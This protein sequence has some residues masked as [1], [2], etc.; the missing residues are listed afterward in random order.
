MPDRRAVLRGPARGLA[1]LRRPARPDRPGAAAPRGHRD[2]DAVGRAERPWLGGRRRHRVSHRARRAPARPDPRGDQGRRLRCGAVHLVVDGA[3][4]RRHRGQA[5]R[6]H[7]RRLHRP[8]DRRDRGRVRAARGRD[9]A[10]AVDGGAGGRAGRVRGRARGTRPLP[11]G[12]KLR[13]RQSRA[14]AAACWR[15]QPDAAGHAEDWCRVP[16]AYRWISRRAAAPAAADARP[17]PPR[18]R[19][20]AAPSRTGAADVR[21]GGRSPSPL[22]IGSMPG[23]VQHTR[24]SAAQGG[25]GAAEAGVGG[26]IVF[27]VPEVK[28]APRLGRRRPGRDLPARAA[29]TCGPR[30]ATTRPHGRPLPG[31]VH[32]PRPLRRARRRRRRRQRRDAAALRARSRSPR[33]TPAPHLVGAERDDGRPGRQRSAPRSTPPGTATSASWPTRPSTR[34]ASTARSARPSSSALRSATGQEL[35]AGLRAQRA[36]GARA[37]WRSTSA[38]APTW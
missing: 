18:L 35:P 26:L 2:R 25:R 33:P 13:L 32:R 5:A 23:V 21:Q 19:D 24:D 6:A 34:P 37:R 10:R 4:P 22:P 30:S 38:R 12:E 16:R 14:S 8:A 27:G 9:R 29:P 11:G 20:L 36:R 3:Q 7:G 31:R 17:A 28:D 1:A 15:R